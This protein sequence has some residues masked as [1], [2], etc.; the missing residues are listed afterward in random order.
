MPKLLPSPWQLIRD[1][2][3]LFLATWN[4]SVKISIWF[5][6]YG[7]A[8]FI[9]YLAIKLVPS[10]IY[11]CVLGSF[12]IMVFWSWTII[13]LFEA[14]LRLN[15]G[16]KMEVNQAEMDRSWKLVLP[17][18]WIGL[19]QV[20]VLLAA[21]IPLIAWRVLVPLYFPTAISS[22]LFIGILCVLLI[23]FMYAAVRLSF[24]QLSALERG[25]RGMD[26]LT[27]SSNLV[28]GNWWAIF[29]R[30]LLA[31][32]VFGGGLWIAT[33]LLFLLLGI[34]VGP[35]KFIM[36]A[37]PTLADPLLKGITSLLEGVLQA[38]S[39][40]LFLIFTVKLYRAVQRNK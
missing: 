22:T 29:F 15:D 14:C 24:S 27:T 21:C 17:L 31:A 38:A 9:I 19:L 40:P 12:V 11:L 36:L 28:A 37:N 33:S 16:K 25:S 1:S 6:Y 35:E 8:Y 30:Q 3:K 5:L 34:I 32:L 18:L 7:L 10:A 13:R 20:L 2:W 39:M 26:A 23:P 4:E